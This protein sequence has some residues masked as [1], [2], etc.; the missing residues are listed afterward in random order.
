[1][2]LGIAA[3]EPAAVAILRR[4]FVGERREGDDR[5][6]GMAPAGEDVRVDEGEGVV[7]GERDAVSRRRQG[8]AVAGGEA[9]DLAGKRHDRVEIDAAFDLVG[10]AVEPRVEVAVLAR[11]DQA[12]MPRG[13]GEGLAAAERAEDR[14]AGRNDSVGDVG[15]VPVGGDAVEDDAGD[16]D[17]GVVRGK[18]ARHG[19]GRLGLAGRVE[20]EENRQAIA[21]GEVGGG[22][23]PAGRAG[24]A[25]E[26]AHRRFD[27]HEV[28]IGRRDRRG[29]RRA[30][31]GPSPRNRG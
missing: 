22:A 18:A 16:A 12:E 11:L 21:G 8:R 28:R 10:D 23:A 3:G 13:Q 19:G 5:R 24:Q 2:Q 30:A 6:A 26:Q 17:G 29:S 27:Q 31:P 25:V 9:A 1:M 14:D 20:D 4:R 7:A 15:A